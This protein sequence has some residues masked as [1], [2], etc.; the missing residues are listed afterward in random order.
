MDG[1]EPGLRHWRMAAAL[2][3]SLMIAIGAIP[4]EAR[5]LSALIDDKLLHF[6]A[7]GF[8]SG[9]VFQSLTG[10]VPG[11]ALRTLLLIAVL[12]ALD[13]ILQSFMPY[14]NAD[15]L[16][17]LFDVLAA[18]WTIALLLV[19]RAAHVRRHAARTV[20]SPASEQVEGNG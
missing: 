17:W 12:G 19:L 2:F 10:S 5:T 18:L 20:N 8:Q 11:R 7:Y 4:G 14:R 16:D 3:F 1:R 6:A 9:L 15:I 13:E